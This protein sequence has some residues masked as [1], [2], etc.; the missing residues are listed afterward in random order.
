MYGRSLKFAVVAC[1]ALSLAA[2]I[3]AQDIQSK[4]KQVQDYTTLACS[5]VPTIGTVTALFN[6]AAGATI[7]SVGSAVCAAVAI[8][9]LSDGPTVLKPSINGVPIHGTY[10]NGRKL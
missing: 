7:N 2:C 8:N 9:P 10:L 6:A 4:V 5:F 3:T 1:A